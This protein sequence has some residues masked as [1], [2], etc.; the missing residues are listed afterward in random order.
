MHIFILHWIIIML[1]YAHFINNIILLNYFCKQIVFR[2][3]FKEF[4][5]R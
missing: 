5:E 2:Y 1:N 3:E 4:F